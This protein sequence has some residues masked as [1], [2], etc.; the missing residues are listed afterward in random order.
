MCAHREPSTRSW[1]ESGLGIA[2]TSAPPG[3]RLRAAASRH[4]HGS[5]R[6]SITCQSAI[7]RLGGNASSAVCGTSLRTTSTPATVRD[8][9]GGAFVHLHGG[10]VEAG[11]PRGVGEPAH[12]RA[13]LDQAAVAF[14]ADAARACGARRR[15]AARAARRR[16]ARSTRSGSTGRGRSGTFVEEQRR[17]DRA[18]AVV[19]HDLAQAAVAVACREVRGGDAA[20]QW[21]GSHRCLRVAGTHG[22]HQD[23]G[24]NWRSARSIKT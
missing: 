20:A 14:G 17:A 12:A 8:V 18:A 22:D 5:G 24:G 11:A 19:E 7:A 16:A 9:L 13:D 10:H 15:A 2:I 3:S 6:C 21:A 4:A 23:S 1:N